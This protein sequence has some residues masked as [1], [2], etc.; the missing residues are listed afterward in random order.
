M[1][2]TPP[3][4]NSINRRTPPPPRKISGSAQISLHE[5]VNKMQHCNNISYNCNEPLS[6]NSLFLELLSKDES[7]SIKNK[8]LCI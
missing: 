5:T 3:P 1:S 8:Y 4:E 7:L 2:K 6:Q